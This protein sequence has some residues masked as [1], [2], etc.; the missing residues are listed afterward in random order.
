ML[1]KLKMNQNSNSND[2]QKK[3]IIAGCARNI[4][5]HD[6]IFTTI[7]KIRTR[8]KDTLVIIYEN[9]SKDNTVQM[10]TNWQGKDSNIHTFLNS[11]HNCSSIRT[12]RIAFARNFILS[13]IR[14]EPLY[15]Y[16]DYLLWLDMD[17]VNSK[18][19]TVAET[20]PFALKSISEANVLGIFPGNVYKY[21]DIW[22]LRKKWVMEHDCWT[23]GNRKIVGLVA[24]IMTEMIQKL[25]KDD[26]SLIPVESAF[27]GAG[28]YKLSY[29]MNSSVLY[30]GAHTCE[31]VAFN[32]KLNKEQDKLRY[33]I[34]P[35]WK[36]D[37][38]PQHDHDL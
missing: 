7:D 23:G 26:N 4:G 29:V 6:G 31:H 5:G 13:Y 21:Y 37:S 32:E 12:E 18:Y 28:L 3:I 22:A 9:D 8:Y 1:N 33:F 15:K 30:D 27:G 24:R 19:G 17:E 38:Q 36:C 10:I 16:Y 2:E 34:Q 25:D 14:N 35:K 20:L 11:Q